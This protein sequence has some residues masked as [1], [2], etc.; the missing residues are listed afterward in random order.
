[1]ASYTRQLECLNCSQTRSF[2]YH[3]ETAQRL[4]SQA[5]AAKL[6]R[7]ARLTCGR[8]GS[9]SVLV[10]WGDAAPYALHGRTPRRRRSADSAGVDALVCT[11]RTGPDQG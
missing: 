2:V 4:L 10:S 9:T 11:S 3:T 7:G 1:M 8:C 5:E 6:P